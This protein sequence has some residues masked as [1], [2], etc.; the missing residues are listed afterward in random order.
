[1]RLRTSP[2]VGNGLW[3]TPNVRLIG[4]S[5]AATAAIP[6]P[7]L[8]GADLH[9]SED[10][11]P[12]QWL[13]QDRYSAAVYGGSELPARC[14]CRATSYSNSSRERLLTKMFEQ[15]RMSLQPY[16]PL[17]SRVYEAAAISSDDVTFIPPKQT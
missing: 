3:L 8:G 5:I 7:L 11:R 17:S 14:F 12:E 1:M 6:I 4:V 13:V 2:E 9:H 16:R 10:V 15:C